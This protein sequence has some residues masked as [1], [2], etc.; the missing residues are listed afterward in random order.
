MILLTYILASSIILHMKNERTNSGAMDDTG[1]GPLTTRRAILAA[2]GAVALGSL[3]GCTALDGLMDRASQEA[4]ANRNASPA[5][6]YAGAEVGGTT[7]SRSGPVDVR[8]IPPTLRA[9]SGR[10][11]IDGWSTSSTTKAQDYNSSRSNKPSTIWVPD[12][13]DD[14]DGL[15]ELVAALDAERALVVYASAAIAA[16]DERAGDEATAPLDAFINATTKARQRLER[17]GTDRCRTV[18][19]NLVTQQELAEDASVAVAAGDWESADR[20]LRQARRI[21]QGDIDDILG[22]LDSDGDGILDLAAGNFDN[23]EVRGR[24]TIAEQ[25]VVCLPDARVRGGGPALADEITPQRVLDYFM[26]EKAA[27]RCGESD[28]GVAVHRDLSCRDLLTATLTTEAGRRGIDKNDIRRGV[29]AFET[30]GGV[31]VTGATP[32][33]EVAAPML[34]IGPDNTISSVESLDSWGEET[35]ANG[36]TVSPALVCP[37][38]ATPPDCPCPIP[39]LFHVRRIRHDDQLLFVGGWTIDDGALYENSATLLTAGGPTRVVAVTHSET[40]DGGV[41]IEYQDGDDLLLRKRPGRTKYG[42]ITLSKAYAT[43]AEYLPAGAPPVC[44]DGDAY[45]YD[46][47]SREALARHETGGCPG[48]E[49]DAP[50]WSVATALDAPVVH[51]T[52]ADSASNDVKFKAGAELSKAVN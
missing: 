10:I 50:A 11:D 48:E 43:D 44:R 35:T 4:V 22:D 16:V 3:A 18:S 49:G 25:F 24:A 45:C 36:V 19:G 20:L 30:S 28:R 7:T 2:S 15:P 37:A 39:V 31:V 34:R 9:E 47:Q 40:G 8:F 13:D 38:V 27:E 1:S 6:F 52:D 32:D 42:N 33:A 29:A 5:A 51:L 17:C 23:L 46:V 14:G 21:A 26:G 41:G 12:P